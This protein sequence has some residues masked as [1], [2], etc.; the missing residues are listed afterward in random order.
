[1]TRDTHIF[2]GLACG[3][4]VAYAHN[5]SP[6]MGLLLGLVSGVVATLPD[7]LEF[8]GLFSHRKFTHSL[9]AMVIV[10][11]GVTVLELP[12]VLRDSVLMAWCS[13]LVID[14]LT[15]MGIWFFYPLGVRVWLAPRIF[16]PATGGVID[17]FVGVVAA[18]FA[19][20]IVLNHFGFH[21]DIGGWM[22]V[23]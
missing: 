14:A 10:W 12:P 9:L 1:M 6:E 23:H 11:F 15:P 3:S 21:F 5:V 22:Y 18:A 17:G 4:C 8:D 20:A 16:R 19:G 2:V 7:Y 13:H